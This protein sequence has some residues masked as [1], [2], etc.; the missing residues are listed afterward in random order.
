MSAQTA[1]AWAIAYDIHD[2][3]VRARVAKL[4][5]KHAT[6]IQ[7]SVFETRLT[8]TKAQTLFNRLAR[9]I[10]PGDKLRFYALPINAL[11]KSMHQGGT[12]LPEDGP[13]WIL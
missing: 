4:L 6:R 8:P 12:P 2:N 5:E 3:R 13:F 1:I 10:Q 7:G 9:L 11:E